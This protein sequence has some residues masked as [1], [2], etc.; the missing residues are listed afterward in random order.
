MRFEGGHADL[1][2]GP[3]GRRRH[4]LHQT[5]GAHARAGVHDETAFLTDQAID[6]SRVEADLCGA[7]NHRVLERHRKALL[8]VNQR[9]GPVTGVDTA[10]PD[11]ALAGQIGRCQQ[12][13]VAHAAALV[14]VGAVVPF[15]HAVTAQADLDRVQGAAQA[16][17]AASAF[18][19]VGR[20]GL[21]PGRRADAL[22]QFFQRQLLVKTADARN[23]GQQTRCF[24]AVSLPLGQGQQ[25]AGPPIDPGGVL[26]LAVAHGGGGH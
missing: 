4:D 19:L 25:R 17:I 24:S 12:F 20:E 10:V 15:A 7:L 18:L 11:L 13:A 5:G 6:I 8:E 2:G 22:A 3:A 1:L 26:A 14:Q 16:D 9:F 21:R 23:A